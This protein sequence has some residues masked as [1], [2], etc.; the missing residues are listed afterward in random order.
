MILQHLAQTTI[1][2]QV[3]A[4]GFA[5]IGIIPAVEAADFHRFEKWLDLG[6][7]GT[8]E[9]LSRRR[10]AYRHP[11]GVLP[12][13]KSII[14]LA[15]PYTSHPRTTPAKSSQHAPPHASHLPESGR[16]TIAAYAAAS[17]DYHDWIHEA[18]SGVVRTLDSMFPNLR[19]RAV[20]DSAPLLERHFGNR[21][22]LGWV[23]KNTLLLNRQLGSYFFLA[24]ILTQA[25]L[26]TKIMDKAYPKPGAN[27]AANRSE[28][29]APPDTSLENSDPPLPGLYP[30]TDHCGS[31]TAC[32]DACP[33][34]AFVRPH[35][36]DATRCISYWTIE[37]RG[38]IP[39]EMR[40]EIGDWL[41]GCDA[42]QTVCPWNRKRDADIVPPLQPDA[43]S[44]KTDCTFWLSLTKDEFRRRF[45][46]TPFWRTRLEGMQ[47]NA[48]I[49]AANTNCLEAL[50]AIAR[51][52]D[53]EDDGLRE[54]AHWAIAKLTQPA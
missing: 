33:T 21:A 15:L 41:F 48:I 36:L 12:D 40:P 37:H 24:A 38:S 49:V 46:K 8:M 47:R 32:L 51:F 52:L 10:E 43:W 54:T 28:P 35:V 11:S 26:G 27:K 34:S 22:G 30:H 13:C 4:A 19:S 44:N 9:Y 18:L 1:C 7:G 17:V 25:D 5:C 31:C 20:V 6:Y 23:G 16:G 2:D 53:D 45:R 14:M 50:P 42:C 29:L 39:P 3:E